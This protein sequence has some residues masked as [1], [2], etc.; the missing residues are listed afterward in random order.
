[1]NARY[2]TDNKRWVEATINYSYKI[3]VITP[4]VRPEMLEIVH[5]CLGRQTF[6]DFEWIIASHLSDQ[7]IGFYHFA[8]SLPPK[9]K[10]IIKVED[11]PRR[12][13]DYYRLNGAW[14]AAFKQAQGELI[15][16][17]QDGLWFPPDMLEKFWEHYQNNPKALVSAIGHQYDRIENGKP[18]HRVWTDPRQRTDFGSF[19]EVEPSELEF[20]IASVPKQSITDV[21]G[22]D[23]EFDKYAALSE[24]EMCYRMKK[25]GYQ[26]FLDQGIEYRAIQHPRLNEEWEQRFQLGCVYYNKCLKEIAEGKRLKLDYLS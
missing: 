19:Y 5:K 7:D 26:F 24:K 16:S 13:G 18:E 6:K 20:C 8:F 9:M 3:T 21:G 15:I 4:S 14:N 23:E 12:K 10:R 25:A 22:I 17:I 1:M 11:P 2:D